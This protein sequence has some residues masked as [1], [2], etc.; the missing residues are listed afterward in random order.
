M[1]TVFTKEGFRFF[2]YSNDHMPIHVHVTRGNGEAVF[3]VEGNVILRE[4]V[5]MK[6]SELAKAEALAIEHKELIIRKWHEYFD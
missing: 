2:F 4:S 3:L 5:G 6:T 1:P